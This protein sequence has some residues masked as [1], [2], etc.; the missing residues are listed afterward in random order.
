[1]TTTHSRTAA[2]VLVLA[3]A[4]T[5]V[6]S[7]ALAKPPRTKVKCGDTLTHSVRLTSDLTD[8]TGDGRVIGADGIIVDLN[9][10]TIDGTV[11]QTD[12]P[13]VCARRARASRTIA[14]TTA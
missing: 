3:G 2:A 11:A 5:L 13:E 14:A 12:C 9:G 7:P 6:A 1:M 8:C 4:M 10:H